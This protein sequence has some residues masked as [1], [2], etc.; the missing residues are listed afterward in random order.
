MI[1]DSGI[2]PHPTTVEE[3][4]EAVDGSD[5]KELLELRVTITNLALDVAGIAREYKS[6]HLAE[7]FDLLIQA[8]Y[9]VNK[10]ME[11]NDYK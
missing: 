4:S 5:S 2:N 10:A 1:G 6:V 11:E 8:S 3:D 7:C 9:K